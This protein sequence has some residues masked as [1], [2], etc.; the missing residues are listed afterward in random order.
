MTKFDRFARN[1][2]EADEILTSLPSAPSSG[3]ISRYRHLVW[4]RPTPIDKTIEIEPFQP[5]RRS[6]TPPRPGW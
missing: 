3:H 2:A 1:I 6:A 5:A 4:R